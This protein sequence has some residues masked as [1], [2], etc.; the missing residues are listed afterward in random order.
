MATDQTSF[1]LT[2]LEEPCAEEYNQGFWDGAATG[3][4]NGDGELNVVDLVFSV[5][6]ILNAE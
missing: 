6:M 1:Q 4:V 3:D 2:I 5:N